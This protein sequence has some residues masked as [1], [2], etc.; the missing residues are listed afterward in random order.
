LDYNH[1]L[2]HGKGSEGRRRQGKKPPFKQPRQE[3]R[4][5]PH[6]KMLRGGGSS[7]A[8]E[9]EKLKKKTPGSRG[10]RREGAGGKSLH[11]VGI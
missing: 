1:S 6:C 10:V 2:K 9:R 7:K 8:G 4:M 3:V 5:L 11:G